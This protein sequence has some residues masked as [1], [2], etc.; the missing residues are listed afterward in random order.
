MPYPSHHQQ[1]TGTL[2]ARCQAYTAVLSALKAVGESGTAEWRDRTMRG[3]LRF[4]VGHC[5]P[6]VAMAVFGARALPPQAAMAY[7]VAQLGGG[8][9]A[10]VTLA[11]LVPGSRAARLGTPVPSALATPWQAALMEC[12]LT[13]CLVL[14]LLLLFVRKPARGAGGGPLTHALAPLLVGLYATLASLI[15]TGI[16]GCALNP[17]TSLGSAL[18]SGI[19]N[20]H[21][22]YWVGPY[23]GAT[24][25]LLAY[26]ALFS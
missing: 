22:V 4:P 23:L 24:L 18:V 13:C 5:N 10:A 9:F 1:C 17:A 11:G 12:T 8:I 21:W 19:W 7:V 15:G 2:R 16:S 26:R 25:A 14:M 6:V 3:A 20:S